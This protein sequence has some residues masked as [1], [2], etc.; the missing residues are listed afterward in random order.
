MIINIDMED[1]KTFRMMHP[2]LTQAECHDLFTN[3]PPKVLHVAPVKEATY[4][5]GD[6]VRAKFTYSEFPLNN[7]KKV[8][9]NVPQDPLINISTGTA[10]ISAFTTSNSSTENI[11]SI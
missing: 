1:F 5:Y 7:A 3:P 11:K 4:Q 10:Y 8:I 9:P 6:F 2:S